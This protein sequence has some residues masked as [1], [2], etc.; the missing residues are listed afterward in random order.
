MIDPA[1]VCKII[2]ET[3]T[4]VTQTYRYFE[5]LKNGPKHA[6]E[7]R[8]EMQN[9]SALL[10]SL[11]V[12]LASPSANSTFIATAIINSVEQFRKMVNE[13][14][15]KVEEKQIKGVPRLAWPLA[16]TE[17]KQLLERMERYKTTFMMAF[18]IRT[19]YV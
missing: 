3:I 11:Q 17:M 13:M 1:T 18:P 8:S 14:N 2:G 7:V 16:A 5:A 15:K 6:E 10:G 12:V 19:D 4:I 9:I